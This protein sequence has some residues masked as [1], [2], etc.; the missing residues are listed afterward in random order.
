MARDAGAL[1]LSYDVDRGLPKSQG[2]LFLMS[3]SRGDVLTNVGMPVECDFV[4]FERG[5][6]GPQTLVTMPGDTV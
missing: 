6:P 2:S 3:C 5:G 1:C 4:T